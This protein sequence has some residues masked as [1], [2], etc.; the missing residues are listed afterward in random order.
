MNYHAKYSVSSAPTQW[1]VMNTEERVFQRQSD[2]GVMNSWCCEKWIMVKKSATQ[3]HNWQF[4]LSWN[5]LSFSVNY[6]RCPLNIWW[7]NILKLLDIILYFYSSLSISINGGKSFQKV[8]SHQVIHLLFPGVQSTSM[9]DFPHN[10][11]TF[12]WYIC[13]LVYQSI[14]NK[15][16]VKIC[17]LMFSAFK[18]WSSQKLKLLTLL[19]TVRKKESI[20]WRM[21][22]R[23]LVS[24]Q[25]IAN[26]TKSHHSSW[27]SWRKR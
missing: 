27:L 15:L 24:P 5:I 8:T 3:T 26:S 4:H 21:G 13:S 2:A 1:P 14:R 11:D 10:L 23:E 7:L 9:Q 19:L 18:V 12:S 16:V 20:D 17:V 6:W 25:Q 22:T